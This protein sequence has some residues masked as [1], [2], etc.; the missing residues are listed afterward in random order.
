[1]TQAN[2]GRKATEDFS[3]LFLVSGMEH[4][5]GGQAL[6]NFDVLTPIV[7]WVEK[8]QAPDSITARGHLAFPGRSRPLCPWPRR[9][10]YKGSGSTEDAQNF[11][12]KD[13]P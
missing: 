11:D 8:G 9:A 13:L 12:C 1:M 7:D 5:F 10:V 2:G 6:E 3:R 4:C